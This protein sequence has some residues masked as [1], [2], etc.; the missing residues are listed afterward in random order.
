VIP[1][2]LLS[3]TTGRE[4]EADTPHSLKDGTGARWPVIDGIPYL[5]V[6]RDDLVGRVLAAL[7]RG[8]EEEALVAL[9]PDQDDWWQGERPAPD[10]LARLVRDRE[11]LSLR[12]ALDHLAFGP[13]A[14]YFV[15]RWT[16]PTFLA[17]LALLEAHWNSPRCVFELACGIGHYLRELQGRGYIVSGGDVVF[18]KLWVA[19]HWV[20]GPKPQLV[21]FDAAA[22]WPIEEAPVDLVMCNDAFYFLEP[23][24]E[25]LA[26]MRKTAGDDG[27][28]AVSHIHN[29][30]KPG[31]SAGRAMTAGEVEELFPDALV[32]D[33]A[34]LTRA[35]VE[36]RAPVPGHEPELNGAEAFSVIAGPGCRPAPRAV[37]DGLALPPAGA[38]LRRNPLYQ[39]VD[40]DGSVIRWPS[41]RYEREY[42][43]RATYPVRSHAPEEAVAG[44]EVEAMARRRELVDLPERW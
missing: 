21:C 1:F 40:G 4:L 39:P 3:P 26:C 29:R 35:L 31:F 25:I 41:E 34:E 33:D 5:R 42:A 16:D 38:V 10:R 43:A 8:R 15:N 28:L 23:K 18:A 17:G 20:L 9:L 19:R 2:P 27:W 24:D 13:V 12:E 32:Y 37:K 7:D 44:P 22:G 36:A 14:D 6:G 30:D 11:T